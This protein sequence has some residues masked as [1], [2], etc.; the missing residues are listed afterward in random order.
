[1]AF[2]TKYGTAWGAL[3]MTGGSI[4]WVAPAASYQV[5]GRTYRCL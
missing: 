2:L 3:P 5:D 4:I 1:M